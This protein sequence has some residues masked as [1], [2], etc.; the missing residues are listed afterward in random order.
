M[1]EKPFWRTLKCVEFLCDPPNPYHLYQ[2]SPLKNAGWRKNPTYFLMW[3]YSAGKGVLW[4]DDPHCS[5]GDSLQSPA[6]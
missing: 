3:G 4:F 1:P 6:G 2:S 5:N